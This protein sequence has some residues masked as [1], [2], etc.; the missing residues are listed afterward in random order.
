MPD[1]VVVPLVFCTKAKDVVPVPVPLLITPVLKVVAFAPVRVKVT[2]VLLALGPATLPVKVT[3]EV[4]LLL[5]V[6]LARTLMV[7]ALLKAVPVVIC[8]IPP[9]RLMAPEVLP[10][11]LLA[12]TAKVPALIVVPP[13]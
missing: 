6:L 3:P 8:K 5:M 4:S 9:L 10:K 11:L 1:K 13:L 12:P 7:R 2:G